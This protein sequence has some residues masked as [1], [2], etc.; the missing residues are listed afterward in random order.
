MNRG[1]VILAQNTPET[2]YVYCADVLRKSIKLAMPDSSVTLITDRQIKKHY[3][4]H[5]VLLP[6]GDQ[7]PDSKWKLANDWQVYEASPY[8]YTI[9]LE[10]DMYLPRSIDYWWNALCKHDLV[11]SQTIRNYTNA[12]SP[13]KFYRKFIQ[14]NC[15]PDIYN[16]VTYFRK[17]P[18]SEKFYQIVREVFQNWDAYLEILKPCQQTIPTTDFVYAIAA[19]IVGVENCTLPDFHEFSMIHMKQMINHAATEKWTDQ[20]IYEIQPE[21]LRVNTIPQLYPFHYHVKDFAYELSSR[22]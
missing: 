2:D 17:S 14:E 10:A 7:C 18:L 22:I 21:C 4:D 8:E 19:H 15:L 9:K 20:Y 6:H 3:F 13:E 5:L 12:V 16:A 11:L 1:F